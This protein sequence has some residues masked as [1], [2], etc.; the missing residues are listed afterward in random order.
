MFALAGSWRAAI[1]RRSPMAIGDFC[2]EARGCAI[3]RGLAAAT[4]E[5]MRGAWGHSVVGIGAKVEVQWGILWGG[6][7]PPWNMDIISP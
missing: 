1:G 6:V 5:L 7:P 2:L 3:I 4:F